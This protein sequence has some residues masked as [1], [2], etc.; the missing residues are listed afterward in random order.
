MDAVDEEPIQ[1][2]SGLKVIRYLVW[3]LGQIM[4]SGI[5][6]TKLIWSSSNQVSPS[7]VK[8]KASNVPLKKQVLYA[9]SITLTPGTLSLDLE[10]GEITV[11]ALQKASIEELKQGDMERKITAIWGENK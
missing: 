4:K 8:I 7:L 6:V 5:H 1:I 9:N 3:L 11:H 2:G 10:D